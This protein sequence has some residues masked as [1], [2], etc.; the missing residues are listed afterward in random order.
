VAGSL[1]LSTATDFQFPRL[2]HYRFSR[3]KSAYH[4]GHIAAPVD[5]AK[6]LVNL[7]DPADSVSDTQSL[8][9]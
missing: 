4:N 8:E 7:F 3:L 1:E 9:I 5:A 2:R 6:H